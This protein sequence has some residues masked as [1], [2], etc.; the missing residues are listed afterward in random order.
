MAASLAS[1]WGL[2]PSKLIEMGTGFKL[3]NVLGLAIAG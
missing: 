1:D 3:E 2:L